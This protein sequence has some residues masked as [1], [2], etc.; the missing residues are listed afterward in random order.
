MKAF[1]FAVL[2]LLIGGCASVEWS[3]PGVTAQERA[4]DAQACQQDA[5]R[6]A[7]WQVLD[8]TYPYGGAWVYP[9][10]LGRPL[11]GYPSAPSGDPFGDRYMIQMRL[12][13]FCMRSKG[14][15]LAEVKK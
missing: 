11:V 6:A 9:D 2:L 3:K 8:R 4:A 5:R 7:S 10:P 13:D 15:D 12:T 14:Y 1:C